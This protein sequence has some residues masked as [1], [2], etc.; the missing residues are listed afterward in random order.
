MHLVLH[1]FKKDAR[2]LWWAIAAAL[3]LQARLMYVDATRDDA[4][5]SSQEG[6][7]NLLLPLAWACLIALAV[8]EDSLLGDR[9]FWVSRPYRW[10]VLL[11]SKLLFAAVCVHAP[12]LVADTAILALRGFQPWQW[13]PQLLEKQVM[14]AAALTL[15][16]I[17]LAA[18]LG[19]FAHLALAAIAIAGATVYLS[20]FTSTLHS[21]VLLLVENTRAIFFFGVLGL[22]AAAIV[23]MQFIRR[24]TLAS[25]GVG[26]AAVVVA[27]LV[28][29]C[30]SPVLLARI[31]AVVDPAHAD[32]A[33][34]LT[35]RPPLGMRSNLGDGWISVALPVSLSG[36]PDGVGSIFELTAVD[37]IAPGVRY[38]GATIHS[39]NGS[40][41]SSELEPRYIGSDWL[42]V[43]IR[44]PLFVNLKNA[45]I[46]LKATVVAVL[47]GSGATTWLPVG[48]SQ[49]VAG[50]GR[51]SSAVVE[52]QTFS[53]ER[54]R[55]LRV[56]CES[57]AGFPLA[58]GARLSQTE[59]ATSATGDLI[60]VSGASQTLLSPLRRVQT[61]FMLMQA[62]NDILKHEKLGITPDRLIGWK[63]MDLE[64]PDIRLSDYVAP[65]AQ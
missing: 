40:Y 55:V 13:I 38:H 24:W 14:L 53:R 34:R 39:A 62:P 21:Q 59:G 35:Q 10:P 5:A 48:A 41:A 46:Q 47:H 6:W 26:V 18:V 20:G 11:A 61:H 15:P 1:I 30:L 2:R 49:A 54:L 31:R 56:V 9:Q 36:V 29:A 12:S 52:R 44:R 45:R 27:E 23:A 50:A 37:L 51:C 16:V 57:P 25:R 42:I 17:A 58:P 33:F 28:L 3:A 63:V 8:H 19:T 4:V 43:R 60:A 64:L 7:L 22:A 65:W 32:L